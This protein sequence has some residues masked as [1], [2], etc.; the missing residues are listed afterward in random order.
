MFI[1]LTIF[2]SPAEYMFS[3]T[4]RERMRIS[5][6]EGSPARLRLRANSAHDQV[7]ATIKKMP[8]P[9]NN[10]EFVA[11]QVCATDTNGDLLITAV[12]IDDMVDYG[13]S[14]RTVRGVA[15]TIMRCTPSGESQ[16]KVTLINRDRK[17]H[18][19]D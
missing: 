7:A 8:F 18:C 5:N 10:R 2:R 11:R 14:M 16:C 12:P 19:C 4:S 3:F 6:E 15:R 9:L 13:M 1:R 17:S